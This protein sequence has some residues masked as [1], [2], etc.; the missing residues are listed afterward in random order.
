MYSDKSDTQPKPNLVG[1]VVVETD[2][3]LMGGVGE[4]FDS[5]IAKLRDKFKFGSWQDI[6]ETAK[7]YG[8]RTL[9]Q[10]KNFGFTITMTR[11][12]KNRAREITLVRGRCQTPQAD[13][14]PGEITGMRGLC[15][16]MNWAPREG[17]PTRLW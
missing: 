3:L 15:G 12:L 11:Y 4:K 5:A 8:G 13:A 6:W 14:T 2:D 7:D 16:P 17:M 10:K 9:M 1:V